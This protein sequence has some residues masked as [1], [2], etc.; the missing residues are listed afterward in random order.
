MISGPNSDEDLG[1]RRTEPK[2]RLCPIERVTRI[3][4]KYRLRTFTVFGQ[5]REFPMDSSSKNF[6]VSTILVCAL[7]DE[8][9]LGGSELEVIIQRAL[10]VRI[11]DNPKCDHERSLL[12]LTT[13][14][15]S[16]RS[17]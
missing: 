5:H 16:R 11:G 1:L 13:T 17:M 2:T 6:I 14:V 15:A 3:R 9:G 10:L 12:G 7:L 4:A 8:E